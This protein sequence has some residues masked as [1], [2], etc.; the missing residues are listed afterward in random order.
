M[1]AHT[2]L[3]AVCALIVATAM[4]S[5]AGVVT[6]HLHVHDGLVLV[7]WRSGFAAVS[8]LVLLLWRQGGSALA[9]DLREGSVLLWLSGLFWGV[10]FTA[11]MVALTMTTVAQTLIVESLSP[12]LAALLGWVV[13]RQPLPARTWAAIVAAML[14]MGWI[15]WSDLKFAADAR[16]LLGMAVALAVPLAAAANWVSLRRAGHG[17]PMQPALMI[18]GALSA[19]AVVLPA[20]PVA[21]DLHDLFWLAVLGALQLA[22]PGL[23]AVWAAQRLAPAEVAL[24]GLLEVVFGTLWAWIGAG[25]T[26]AA[27]TLIGGMLVLAALVG[28][29]AF[30]WH[31][32]RRVRERAPA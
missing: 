15:V 2:H 8:V 23:L 19:F 3:R 11:F 18:G 7:F 32:A 17:V 31:R 25:E 12:L 13:L 21:I 26:P 22:V 6:R 5:I 24:L 9:R 16:Q 1:S 14:G 28:N 4:W 27:S 20:W 10:M 30:G 29:E